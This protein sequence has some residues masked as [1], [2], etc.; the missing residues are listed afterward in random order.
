MAQAVEA[1]EAFGPGGVAVLGAGRELADATGP[2]EA[3]EQTG[4]LGA[5]EVADI[6]AEDVVVE[7]GEGGG[8]LFQAGQRVFL[9]VGDVFEEAADVTGR[10]VAGVAFGVEKDEAACPGSEAIPRTVLAEA[11]PRDLA[12]EVQ[13][14]RRLGR[15]R[16]LAGWT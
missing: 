4:R 11:G 15:G 16:A 12:N 9:S 10:K 14:P 6:Q 8:G 13:E 3:V 5:R 1:D 7:E 2:A